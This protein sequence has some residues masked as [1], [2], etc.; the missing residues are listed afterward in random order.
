MGF[1]LSFLCD[2]SPAV[3]DNRLTLAT[4]WV[5]AVLFGVPDEN[6]AEQAEAF[7]AGG[8][9]RALV[10]A[11]DEQP[12]SPPFR[13]AN[14]PPSFI[15]ILL[16][17]NVLVTISTFFS[18]RVASDD[19]LALVA[20]AAGLYERLLVFSPEPPCREF[21][22]LASIRTSLL[23]LILPSISL[24]PARVAG[25]VLAATFALLRPMPS[26]RIFINDWDLI[27]LSKVISLMEATCDRAA[28]DVLPRALLLGRQ[29]ISELPDLVGASMEKLMLVR[30]SKC[31]RYVIYAGRALPNSR[32]VG[33]SL[34]SFSCGSL[35]MLN[36]VK[37]RQN[38][39]L[40]SE[41]AELQSLARLA[42]V[43]VASKAGVDLPASLRKGALDVTF[44]YLHACAQAANPLD[45]L[46][47][48]KI[49]ICAGAL[50]SLLRSVPAC[51][52]IDPAAASSAIA[53]ILK[54]FSE[55]SAK[56]CEF[57]W[58][59]SFRALLTPSADIYMPEFIC[60]I[61]GGVECLVRT[62]DAF[63]AGGI[64]SSMLA[65]RGAVTFALEQMHSLS[66]D[67]NRSGKDAPQLA[68]S[69]AGQCACLRLLTTL[70]RVSGENAV[71]AVEDLRAFGVLEDVIR[72]S[73]SWPAIEKESIAGAV[74]ELTAA[75]VGL[76]AT[77]PAPQAVLCRACK[78]DIKNGY[79][80]QLLKIPLASDIAD[81]LD[82]ESAKQD[83]VRA[84]TT[85]AAR[86][87]ADADAADKR[88]KADEAMAALLAE[89]ESSASKKKTTPTAAAKKG[90]KKKS[91]GG[92][93]GGGAAQAE[94]A[95]AAAEEEE[96]EAS[97]PSPPPPP[98]AATEQAPHASAEPP[99]PPPAPPAHSQPQTRP[100]VE[101]EWEEAAPRAKKGGRAVAEA[102]PPPPPAPPSVA[103][104]AAG[105]RKKEARSQR[106]GGASGAPTSPVR[107]EHPSRSAGS[108]RPQAPP[109]A[110]EWQAGLSALSLGAA[111]APAPAPHSAPLQQP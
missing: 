80:S 94:A 30:A 82:N 78:D 51:S 89:E 2:H 44:A 48:E 99:S 68:D 45:T 8:V 90:A 20:S 4:N 18:T 73:A 27:A 35:D 81:F 93:G 71:R 11:L 97:P 12:L 72:I 65:P 62:L 64:D 19:T 6:Q 85:A 110:A 17:I 50:E 9:A 22:D 36:N 34:A 5:H 106:E 29:L 21:D 54:P 23:N 46:L 58:P 7:I 49:S 38:G 15:K 41:Y 100:V 61:T 87:Q 39:P 16:R 92:G 60:A 105:T 53:A 37:L 1:V 88:K 108:W 75:L 107:P 56:R 13:H 31:V 28:A 63:A 24:T 47:L 84:A 40:A 77:N 74:L 91:R 43:E 70:A 10:A 26:P 55:P 3:N 83:A 95:A 102:A 104:A 98:L 66:T 25:R 42:S 59:T 103:A 86:A 32:A 67:R 57:S 14:G 96:S 52:E 109:V 76:G 33:A 69:V 111:T 79:L 101:A